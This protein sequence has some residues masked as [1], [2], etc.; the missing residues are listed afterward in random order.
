MA[1][2][3]FLDFTTVLFP[4]T[5]T[6]SEPFLYSCIFYVFFLSLASNWAPSGGLC[7]ANMILAYIYAQIS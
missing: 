1:F 3:R 5:H 6:N 2:E 7:Q 4:L